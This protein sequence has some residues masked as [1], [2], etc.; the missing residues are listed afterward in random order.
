MTRNR[1]MIIA[2]LGCLLLIGTLVLQQFDIVRTSTL[3]KPTIIPHRGASAYAPEHT[4][5]A[6]ELGE[7]MNGDYIEL[8]LQMTKD[9]HLIV[10]HDETVN[11]T[12][13][14]TGLVRNMTLADIKQLDAGSW[15]NER[16]PRLANKA[17][18]GLKVPTLEEVMEHFGNDVRFYIETKAPGVY[19]GM[20]EELLRIL[21]KHEMLE[22]RNVLIQS[23]S[24]DSLLKLHSLQPDLP[25][26]QLIPSASVE[27]VTREDLKDMK[28]YS[29]GIGV[30]YK[31]IDED[32]VNVAQEE[33]LF[34]HV[35]TVNGKRDIG[36]VME[37][38]VDGI[39][40][41]HPDLIP[42]K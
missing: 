34:V 21:K 38:G 3:T 2:L 19:P 20:E 23:F 22:E 1:I 35:Y 31:K 32:F 16:Y 12:T 13:N 27:E 25:L 29:S 39:F 4:I 33:S 18:V 17:Y 10:M 7:T 11:R 26:V 36:R 28:A 14:G 37:W 40:T 30:N 42:E 41:N 6:Y 15:F 5:A 8:D 24:P 9:N